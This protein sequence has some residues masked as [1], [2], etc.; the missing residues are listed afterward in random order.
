M[1][2]TKLYENVTGQDIDVLGV[3]VVPANDR[4]SVTSE[5]PTPVNLVN[6]PGVIEV[7]GLTAEDHAAAV[8][9]AQAAYHQLNGTQETP[10][11]PAGPT[12]GDV[13]DV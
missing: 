9:Q 8:E 5:Y 2:I 7:S 3:G 10:A 11:A 6:Y 13:Q 12:E 1:Q 4:L